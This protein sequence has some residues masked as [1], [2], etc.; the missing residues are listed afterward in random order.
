VEIR[1]IEAFLA[2]ADELHFGRAAQ[3]LHVTTASVSQAIRALERQVG[4]P[5][6]ERTSRQVV[7][8]PIGIR[9]LAGIR[10]AYGQLRHSLQEA[11]RASRQGGRDV[12]R[13]GFS[14]TVPRDL[15]ALVVKTFE[16]RVAGCQIARIDLPGTE[17]F[18]WFEGGE[19]QTDV[20][21]GWLPDPAVTS[22]PAPPWVEIGP[23]IRR[24]A[25]CALMRAGH[26]L[27]GGRLIAPPQPSPRADQPGTATLV[28]RERDVGATRVPQ[29]H[30]RRAGFALPRC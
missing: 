30:V 24:G 28:P 26:P 27:S 18:R 15:P 16:S 9:L 6:F 14:T 8:T 20:F 23:V 1:E 17:V 21:I 22:R 7:L 3:R 29:S 25:R 19:F 13:V 12:L 10:P 5:L 4:V 2:V 11:Q